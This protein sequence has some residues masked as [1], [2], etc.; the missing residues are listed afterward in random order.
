MRKTTQDLVT[1]LTDVNDK[2]ESLLVAAKSPSVETYHNESES[3]EQYPNIYSEAMCQ[4]YKATLRPTLRDVDL[5]GDVGSSSLRQLI[6]GTAD[7]LS[8]LRECRKE[9][10]DIK[11]RNTG[12]S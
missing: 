4:I 1:R 3:I 7:T 9:L 5:K 10:N 8:T 6:M 11:T 12:S 2:L